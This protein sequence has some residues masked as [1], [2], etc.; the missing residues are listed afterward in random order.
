MF[1]V[2][3]CVGVEAIAAI[4]NSEESWGLV[5]SSEFCILSSEFQ[6]PF[7]LSTLKTFQPST[8]YFGCSGCG[9]EGCCD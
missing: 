2:S 9:D 8:S 4:P 6:K 1:N 7:N 5:L 3:S